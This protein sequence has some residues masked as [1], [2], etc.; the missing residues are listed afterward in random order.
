MVIN[1]GERLPRLR[2]EELDA[3]QRRVYDAIVGGRRAGQA[4]VV[5]LTDSAGSLEGPFG[6]LLHAPALGEA[7]QRLGEVMRTELSLDHRTRE[8]ATLRCAVLADSDYELA[9]HRRLADAAGVSATEIAQLEAGELPDTLSEPERLCVLVASSTAA[10]EPIDDELFDQAVRALGTNGCTEA[11]LL[12]GYYRMLAGLL[13]AF[14][15]TSIS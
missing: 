3:A 2:P 7:V 10:G 15:I 5:P 9:A 4:S 1:V 14:G 11:V 6:P 13:Q 12:G 8:L